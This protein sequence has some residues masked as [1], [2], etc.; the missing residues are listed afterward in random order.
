MTGR[1][2]AGIGSVLRRLPPGLPGKA[3]FAR[4]VL[5][6][7]AATRDVLVDLPNGTRMVIP[8]LAEPVG[9]HL[10]IDGVYEPREVSWVLDHLEPGDVFLDV[11]ANIG[12]F[13]I[14][15]ARR[16]GPAG[17]VIAVEASP[18][19]AAC[20]ERNVSLNQLQN[21]VICQ[22]AAGETTGKTVSFFEAPVERFGMGSLTPVRGGTPTPVET[23]RLDDLLA[24]LG[25][26]R[27]KILKI[28]V[29]GFE[30]E[31]FRGAEN[32]LR[33]AHAPAVLFEFYDWAEQA[34]RQAGDAQRVLLEFGYRIW[35]LDAHR[36][37]RSALPD[38]L[39]GGHGG[40]FVA[41]HGGAA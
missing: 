7:L 1:L 26:D 13:A 21:I 6:D 12:A 36:S 28:D 10:F 27:V 4:R 38:L 8:S 23:R 5:G 37:G 22:V 32:L 18:R 34:A 20:L 3:R 25:V 40:N 16:V 29:E 35:T 30:C 2:Q 19:V 24:G 31:A 9:F 11:G 17:R 39:T 41:I 33:S 15:A 14:P